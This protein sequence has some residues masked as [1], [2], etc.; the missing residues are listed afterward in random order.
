VQSNAKQSLRFLN[1]L[2]TVAGSLSDTMKLDDVAEL[3]RFINVKHND[4]T[5]KQK[6]ASKGKKA[7][8]PLGAPKKA[9]SLKSG[10]RN[11]YGDE[12]DAYGDAADDDFM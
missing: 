1:F 7:A 10:S 5:N 12:L 4:Q 2:K 11:T 8:A 6:V 3:R 9:N